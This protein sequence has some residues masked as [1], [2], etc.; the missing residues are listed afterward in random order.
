MMPFV[1]G[2]LLA[3][4]AVLMGITVAL[5]LAF[6]GELPSLFARAG[7]GRQEVDVALGLAFGLLLAAISQAGARRVRW[8]GDMTDAL[9]EILRPLSHRDVFTQAL[10][11]ALAEEMFFRGFLQ[12]R[13]GLNLTSLLFG[14]VHFPRERRLRAWQPLGVLLGYALGFM[15]EV[16]GSLVAPFLAHFTINFFNMHYVL[17]RRETA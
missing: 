1:A 8:L 14:L 9:A 7:V 10:F 5:Q 17:G 4:Y 15:F 12:A 2:M 11:S 16:R 13:I 6:V 3:F